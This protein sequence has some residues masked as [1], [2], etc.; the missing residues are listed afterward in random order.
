[1]KKILSLLVVIILLTLTITSCNNAN[2]PATNDNDLS[3]EAENTSLGNTEQESSTEKSNSISEGLEFELSEDN[4]SYVVIGIGTCTDKDLNIPSEYNGKPVVSIQG[5]SISSRTPFYDCDFI[6][7]LIIPATVTEIGQNA[8]SGAY[9]LEE[10]TMPAACQSL[11][12]V[13][14]NAKYTNYDNSTFPSTLTKVTIVGD[15]D[16]SIK[17]FYTSSNII[18]IIFIF[19]KIM[20]I[21]F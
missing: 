15:L 8:L 10:I 21:Y 18:I 9:N 2:S 7:V 13:F 3:A 19:S 4:S 14:D 16:I 12:Y 17:F 20:I 6:K 5:N 1:M 11:S